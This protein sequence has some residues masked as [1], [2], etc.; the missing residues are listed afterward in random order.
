VSC[1]GGQGSPEKLPEAVALPLR[2]V[3]HGALTDTP[4]SVYRGKFYEWDNKDH[5]ISPAQVDSLVIAQGDT[6]EI[7]ACGR[8]DAASGT[9]GTVDLYQGGTKVC[10]LYWN[11]PWGSKTN[12]FTVRDTNPSWIVSATGANTDGGALGTVEVKVASFA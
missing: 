8:S 4:F 6:K 1:I 12:T 11:C 5:E 2:G 7:A 9:E 3:W 10:Q